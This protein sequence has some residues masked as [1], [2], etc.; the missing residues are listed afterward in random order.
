[1]NANSIDYIRLRQ[2]RKRRKS[3]F[4]TL[5]HHLL[6]TDDSI[7]FSFLIYSSILKFKIPPM[8]KNRRRRNYVY[9]FP[10][11][12]SDLISKRAERFI[13]SN[14][15]NN[16][17]RRFNSFM[18]LLC[19]VVWCQL[20]RVWSIDNRLRCFFLYLW[21]R[22]LLTTLAN[23]RFPNGWAESVIHASLSFQCRSAAKILQAKQMK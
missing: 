2:D 9:R 20:S 14:D 11:V 21:A 17:N 10:F 5:W 18:L 16:C 22:S 13:R 6:A 19:A 7:S 8:L 23:N 3:F 4:Q 1:M 15:R 12:S